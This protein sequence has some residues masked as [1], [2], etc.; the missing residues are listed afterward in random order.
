MATDY[1]CRKMRWKVQK[2]RKK[3][4]TKRGKGDYT[5]INYII[6]KWNKRRQAVSALRTIWTENLFPKVIEYYEKF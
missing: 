3:L 6:L 1:F 4:L 2:S 5:L